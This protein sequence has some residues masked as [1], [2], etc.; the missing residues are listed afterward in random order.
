CKQ[1]DQT[2]VQQCLSGD[3]RLCQLQGNFRG[4]R[5]IYGP[6][7]LLRPMS[8]RRMLISRQQKILMKQENPVGDNKEH[9]CKEGP[10][11]ATAISSKGL[12]SNG[13]PFGD[14]NQ[15]LQRITWTPIKSQRT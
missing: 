10:V 3:K 2:A 1:Q 13:Y 4:Q 7:R 15:V 9:F 8:L 5:S 14:D 12:P 11:M 6:K